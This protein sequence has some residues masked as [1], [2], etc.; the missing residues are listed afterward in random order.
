M[1]EK[2]KEIIGNSLQELNLWI[3]DVVYEKENNTNYL[4]ICLD[5]KDVIDVNLIVSATRIINPL[6][7]EADLINEEYILDIYGK[8][9]GE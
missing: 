7:D 9:K 6:I 2:V 1:K 8:S 3:D 4:R 5:S